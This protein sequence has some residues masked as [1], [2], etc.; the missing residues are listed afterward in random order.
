MYY[1]LP[2]NRIK[3]KKVYRKGGTIRC[4]KKSRGEKNCPGEGSFFQVGAGASKTNRMTAICR[5]CNRA[6]PTNKKNKP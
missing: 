4:K 3:L 6:V 1:F 5:R 2:A